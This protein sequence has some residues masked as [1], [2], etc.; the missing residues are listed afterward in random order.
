MNIEDGYISSDEDEQAALWWKP[1]PMPTRQGYGY[2]SKHYAKS[3]IISS[4]V[5][6]YG[7][8]D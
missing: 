3:D 5:N 2:V 6:I 1:A 4:L 7:S 8:Q